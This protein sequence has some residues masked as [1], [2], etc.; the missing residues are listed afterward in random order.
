MTYVTSFSNFIR[1][2]TSTARGGA[3]VGMVFQSFNLIPHLTII[4]NLV[5]APR[6]VRKS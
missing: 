6:L 2:R 4:G 3:K 1:S 5:L